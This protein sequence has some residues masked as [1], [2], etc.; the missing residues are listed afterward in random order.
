VTGVFADTA[1]FGNTTLASTGYNDVFITK[2]DGDGNFLWAAQGNST[3]AA[4]GT[5]IATDGLGNSIVIGDFA[6]VVT[7]GDNRLIADG[8]RDIFIT[9]LDANGSFLWAVQAGGPVNTPGSESDVGRSIARDGFDNSIG[10]GRFEGTATFGD[11]TLTSA[12]GPDIFITKLDANGNFLWA[13][14]AGGTDGGEGAGIA[15]DGLG[16]SIVTGLFAGTAT[17]GDTTLS[18]TGNFDIFITK[19]F[20]AGGGTLEPDI[21]VS[22][23]SY[24]YGNVQVGDTLSHT[25]VV[26]N[27]GT[28][29]LNISGGVITGSVDFSIVS[30]GGSATVPPG[31]THNVVVDFAPANTGDKSDT[32]RIFSDDPDEGTLDVPLMGV[33]IDTISNISDFESKIPRRFELKQNYPNPFN[34]TTKITYTLPKASLVRLTIYNMLGQEVR[35]LVNISQAAGSYAVQWNGRHNSGAMVPSGIYLYKIEAGEFTQSRK[36]VLLK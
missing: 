33:G 27:T 4:K 18:S 3:V 26:S 20:G 28:A 12:G 14:Q 5:G 30:G 31:N 24:D 2:L 8:S 6:G 11:T 15:T 9:K 34:P 1:T 25:F 32:L 29:N 17:F 35:S 21:S 22:P 36:M 10:T 19:I 13:A 23:S 7:I 16:N